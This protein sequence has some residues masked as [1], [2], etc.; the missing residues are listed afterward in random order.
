M[1]NVTI[2]DL[3]NFLNELRLQKLV[4]NGEELACY[5]ECGAGF[6]R[7]EFSRA[8]WNHKEWRALEEELKGS[9]PFSFDL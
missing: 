1:E 5:S 9:K 2:L 4:W 8:S 6:Y 3:V 7:G